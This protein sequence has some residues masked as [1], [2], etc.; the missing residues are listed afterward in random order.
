MKC[1]G[2]HSSCVREHLGEAELHGVWGEHRGGQELQDAGSLIEFRRVWWSEIETL[3][4]DD[5]LCVCGLDL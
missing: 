4:Y 3:I 5:G 1:K 2:G